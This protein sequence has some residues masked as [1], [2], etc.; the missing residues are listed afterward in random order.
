MTR[1]S[2]VLD[3]RESDVG[4]AVVGPVASTAK[5]YLLQLG[6]IAPL[7]RE[8]NHAVVLLHGFNVRRAEGRRTLLQL[9]AALDGPV[10]ALFLAVLWPGDDRLSPLTYPFEE[11]DADATARRLSHVLAKHLPLE[12]QLSF[13]AHSL[14]CRVALETMRLLLVEHGRTAS[15]VVLMAAAVDQ[16]ALARGDRYVAAVR[17]ARRVHWLASTADRV[18]QFAYPPGDLVGAIISGSYTR[19]ALG[20]HGPTAHRAEQVPAHVVGTQLG[21]HRVGHGDYLPAP[22]PNAHQD[23]AIRYNHAALTGRD[24]SY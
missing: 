11:R 1:R 22:S 9:A 2:L 5:G 6:D 15:E 4:G 23:K 7:A 19:T 14:G 16:D 24:P 17:A 3:F 21:R 8:T 12:T 10:S 20:R 18:L 13:V